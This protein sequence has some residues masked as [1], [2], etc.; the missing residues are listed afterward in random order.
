[1]CRMERV[2]DRNTRT[3]EHKGSTTEHHTQNNE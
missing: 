3:A 2:R 1:M